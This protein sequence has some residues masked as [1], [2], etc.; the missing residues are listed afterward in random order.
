M[1]WYYPEELPV[2]ARRDEI[3][4]AMRDHDVIVVVSE[5]GSGKTTQLPKMVTEV[6]QEIYA[7]KMGLIGVTQP[8]RIAA[9]S[10][11]RRVAEELR[12]PLG[13]LVGYQVRFDE[14]R[15]AATRIKFMTDGILLAETQGDRDLKHYDAIVLDEAHER[16]LNIDFLL[17]YLKELRRRRPALKIIISSATLDAGAFADFFTEPDQE[18]PILVAE[19]RTY[20][21]EEC[22]LPPYDDEDLSQHVARAC[23]WLTDVDAQGDVLVFLP[24]EKE[25]RESADTLVGR[26]YYRT[27]ILPLF[28]R[29]SM[30]DQ[31]RVFAPGNLRRIILATNVAETSLTIP[32]I[33]SVVD[34]G[35]ARVSRWSPARGVQRLQVEPVSQ[36]SARQR[37]GRCGRVK[38]G[39]CVRLYDELDLAER[40]EFTDPEIRRSSLAGVILRMISLGLPE[41]ESFPLIDAPAPKAVA[42]GYRTLRD[43]GA[44][45]K[46][47]R[48]T[49]AG[50]HMARMPIDPRLAR[51]LMEAQHQRCIA[52]L[53]PVIAAL[54]SS[55]PRERPAEKQK[56]A[57]AAHARWKHP[58]SDFFSL[59]RLWFD[60]QRFQEKGKWRRNALRKYCNEAFL[61]MRRVM[62]WGNVHDELYDLLK[63]ELRWEMPAA[64]LGHESGDGEWQSLY[65]AFHRSL[66]AGVPRQFGL[67]DVQEKIYRSAAGGQFAIFPGSGLFSAKRYDWV[68]A[69]EIVETTRLWAR[70][71]ARLDPAWVEQVAGH[72]CTRRYG[73]GYWDEK[74]GAVYAKETVLCGGLVVVKDRPVHLGRIDPAAARE[75]FIR[76]GILGGGIRAGCAALDRLKE[77]REDVQVM[78][79]KLRQPDRLW[80]EEQVYEFFAA[81]IPAGMCTA[82]AFHQWRGDHEQTLIPSL[83][84]VIWD[85]G[86][87]DDLQDFPDN[88]THGE[89]EYSV[90]Y[91]MTPGARDDGVTIGVHIDQLRDFPDHLLEW[92]VIGHLAERVEF[93]VRNLPK[94]LRKACQPIA[95]FVDDFVDLH[96]D[97]PHTQSLQRA[98]TAHV[99]KRLRYAVEENVIDLAALPPEWQVKC[100]V[101]DDEGNEILLGTDLRQMRETLQPLLKKRLEEHANDEWQCSGAT[102]WPFE[103]IPERVESTGGYAY[104][105]LVDEGKS[106]G[107]R[108]FHCSAQAEQSHRAGCARLLMLAQPEQVAYLQ[109]KFPLGLAA[110]VE[111]SRIGDGGTTMEDLI[112]LSAE[113]ALG[114]RLPRTGDDFAA[115][116]AKAKGDWVVAATAVGKV[117]DLLVSEIPQ[118]RDW[119]AR[120]ASSRYLSAVADDINEQLDWLMRRQFC[121]YTGFSM[122]GEYPR[123]LRAIRMRIDR[124]DSLPIAKD[125]EKMDRVRDLWEPWFDAWHRDSQNP[126][127]WSMGWMLEE[128]RISLFAPGVPVKGTIS[129]KKLRQ[130][131]ES[132]LS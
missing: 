89:E 15:S 61:S 23:D 36:A 118:L 94:D 42:E 60:V 48:L 29:L 132:R 77:L 2:V 37:K 99:Q 87:L 103:Q 105:A 86:L 72:L 80:S 24:G 58:Q 12:Q 124:L 126:V 119:C 85:Q 33:S 73:H 46:D 68:L 57:D 56:E 104:P 55:D 1:N 9:V 131:W 30:G 121:W 22:F 45:T 96:A 13:G 66:L 38:E 51:M 41:I 67:W 20:P 64:R 44:I 53:L 97:A 102:S 109:K 125:L 117:L 75:V 31:Q 25:I 95:D 49:E 70:R 107:V 79:C 35:T 92:G 84:D 128:Y 98:L 112:R 43:V 111:L 127:L 114:A 27:E 5:T 62:E 47:K 93:L 16:S 65:D 26:N 40:P 50:K 4:Q 7:D 82:K 69:M 81:K 90:Y 59:L 39:I 122:L 71:L 113:G 74:Q 54:E 3:M 115:L 52:E 11:A 14:K 10:V 123:Y 21:V 106:V 130:M 129:E 83:A 18:V 6:L 120:Q 91:A 78:E 63:R 88:L 17:G 101:C 8:R 32:R 19:G 34:S 116:A 100:W 28:A 110:R 108:A 76:D